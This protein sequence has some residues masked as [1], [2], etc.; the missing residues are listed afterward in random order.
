MEGLKRQIRYQIMDSKRAFSIFWSIVLGLNIVAYFLSMND[1]ISFGTSMVESRADSFG[2]MTT[3]HY[4]NVASGNIIPIA[5]FIIVYCMV[6]YYENFP[7]VIGFS[8]TRKNFYLGVIIHNIILCFAMAVIEGIL[9]TLDKY[10]VKAIGKQPLNNIF[11]FNL[12]KDNVAYV[13]TILFLISLLVCSV[14]NLLGII[15]YKYG[16]RFWIVLGVL[17][18]VLLKLGIQKS[19]STNIV[20]FLFSFHGLTSFFIK[21]V[22]EV[23]ILYALGWTLIRRRGIRDGK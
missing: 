7:T 2:N 1:N 8:S 3:T 5:I 12:D 11:M 16:Y 19:V 20:D 13:I 4:M 18:F 23:T 10:I 21:I 17:S 9:I 14:F 15:L 22:A 6:M